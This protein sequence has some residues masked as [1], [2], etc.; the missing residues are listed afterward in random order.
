MSTEPR[1]A[2]VNLLVTKTLE[3]DEPHWCAGHSDDHAQFK[4]DITHNG[5]EHVITANG[6]DLFRAQLAQ[7]PYAERANPGIVLYI[8]ECDINRSYTPD[9]V[10]QL[11]DALIEA[12]AQLRALGRELAEL[13]GGGE[14]Q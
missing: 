10:E 6:I 8:E 2:T 9:E 12:A 14:G 4:P 13:L 5:P 11:A 7:S 3:I 1:T